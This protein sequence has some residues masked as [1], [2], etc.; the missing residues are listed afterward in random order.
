MRVSHQQSTLTQRRLIVDCAG[1]VGIG[2]PLRPNGVRS[3]CR[4]ALL[5]LTAHDF[6]YLRQVTF[7]SM[8]GVRFTCQSDPKVG[9]SHVEHLTNGRLDDC[10][11]V[12]FVHLAVEE[13][14][15]E[16]TNH[17][18]TLQPST[19]EASR[20]GR[21]DKAFICCPDCTLRVDS[22][23]TTEFNWD[24]TF[25]WNLGHA[26]DMAAILAV[27]TDHSLPNHPIHDRC[28]EA[29]FSW[30]IQVGMCKSVAFSIESVVEGLRR[31]W[32]FVWLA[33]GRPRRAIEDGRTMA[34]HGILVGLIGC[35]K[36]YWCYLIME[37]A[38]IRKASNYEM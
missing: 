38:T 5:D 15:L 21:L 3:I 8:N 10:S 37:S 31:L 1:I 26:I 28:A 11:L 7:G 2:R 30:F 6:E 4:G 13:V 34:F 27:L 9:V 35:T 29:T 32:G 18:V 36:Q 14:E 23:W 17:R 25:G 16:V 24:W 20:F 33:N 12:V 19:F 22:E